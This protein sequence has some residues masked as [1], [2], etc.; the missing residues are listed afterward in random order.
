MCNV[1]VEMQ[2]VATLAIAEPLLAEQARMPGGG[3]ILLVE[4][5]SR[6]RALLSRVLREHGYTVT[7]VDSVVAALGAMRDQFDLLV[8]DVDLGSV[9]TG[10]DMVRFVHAIQPGLP[11][12]ILS[13]R[14]AEEANGL[15]HLRKPCTCATILDAV[16]DMVS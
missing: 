16:Q 5:D 14:D 8:T 10:M 2:R 12:L 11:V 3:R 15:P 4:D 7:A 13:A 9:L 1:V 6:Q